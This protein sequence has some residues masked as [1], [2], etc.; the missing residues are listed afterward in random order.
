M[1]R[2]SVSQRQGRSPAPRQTPCRLRGAPGATRVLAPRGL[3]ADRGAGTPAR[4]ARATTGMPKTGDRRG[5]EGRRRTATVAVPRRKKKKKVEKEAFQVKLLGSEQPRFRAMTRGGRT[6]GVQGTLLG[7]AARARRGFRG[8][9]PPQRAAGAGPRGAAR[10]WTSA[11][12]R[13]GPRSARPSRSR[14]S[15]AA[16]PACAP[17]RGRGGPGVGAEG[18]WFHCSG[19]SCVLVRK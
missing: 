15:A 5:R 13:P 6:H 1:A 9:R 11:Q 7:S 17:L 14:P 3:C 4:G 16:G 2:A 12:G 18:L 19:G 8:R 10:R